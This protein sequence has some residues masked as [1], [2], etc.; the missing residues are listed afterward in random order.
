MNLK[1]VGGLDAVEVHLP[2][3]VVVVARG[4]TIQLSPEEASSL[5]GNPDWTAQSESKAPKEA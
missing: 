1:Y 4:E 2:S 3:R 5:E